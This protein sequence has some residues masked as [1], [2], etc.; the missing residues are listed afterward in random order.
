M[1]PRVEEHRKH[2]SDRPL[3]AQTYPGLCRFFLPGYTSNPSRS[4][5]AR[6]DCGNR[7]GRSST[8]NA[9]IVL[10]SG[11]AL[12][13]CLHALRTLAWREALVNRV[14][15]KNYR[16]LVSTGIVLSVLLMIAGKASASFVQI[17]VPPFLWREL[18]NLL[19]IS[20][21][22]IFSAAFLPSSHTRA[23]AGHP[24][25]T[26]VFIWGTAHLVSNGDLASM[27]MFGSLAVWSALS[28]RILNTRPEA[29]TRKASAR[30]ALQWDV[31]AILLG[32]IAYGVLL[33]FHGPL[34]GF[35]LTGPV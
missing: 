14:G 31:A 13:F 21:C 12:F 30:P 17:W 7:Q 33:V 9:L 18:T 16:L 3:P 8:G 6:H 25:L 24:L 26:G 23:L 2:T 15:Q 27:L 19:M 5:F 1:A 32:M 35:A 28:I 4:I 10:I 20:A 34:F 11:L 29:A 22:I